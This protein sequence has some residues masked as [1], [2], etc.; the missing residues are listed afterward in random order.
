MQVAEATG[1]EFA[2]AGW[3]AVSQG[4]LESLQSCHEAGT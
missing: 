2:V 3:M 4:I 1:C